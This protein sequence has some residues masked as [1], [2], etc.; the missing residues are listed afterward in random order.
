M[1]DTGHPE[2]P[3]T[4]WAAVS[5]SLAMTREGAR[6]GLELERGR[7]PTLTQ[8]RAAFGLDLDLV[9]AWDPLRSVRLPERTP[10]D[11]EII[12]VMDG[13]YR[14]LAS[15]R[16]VTVTA[17]ASGLVIDG[18]IEPIPVREG[19]ELPLWVLFDNPSAEPAEAEVAYAGST[20]AIPVDAGRVASLLVPGSAAMQGQDRALLDV[21]L[22][23]R[24]SSFA[25]PIAVLPAW[26]LSVSLVDDATGEPVPARVYLADDAGPCAPNDA[27]LRRDEHGNAF[28]HAENAFT[29]AVAGTARITVHRGME[30][31]PFTAMVEPPSSAAASI[32]AR[33]KRWSDQ[34]ADGWHSGDVHVHLHYGGE[35]LLTPEHASLVQR[36]EDVRFMNMMVAN[37]GSGY[38]NDRAWFTGHDHE[39]STGS[40]ILRWGEEYRNNFYGHLCMYGLE[41]LVPPIYSG[42]R[43]SEHE[44]DLPANAH[45]AD[46]AHSVGGTLS[47]A[48][49]MFGS[50][51]LDRIFS[52][53][54]TVEAKELPVDVALGKVD[55]LDVMSYPGIDIEVSELWYRL[56]NCGFQLPATA[57]TDTFMNFG[58]TGIFSNPPAVNRVFVQLDGPFTTEA[59]CEGVR[60]GRTF[61]TNGPMLRLTVDGQPVGSR[62]EARPGQSFEVR[63]EVTSHFP[64]EKLQLILNRVVVAEVAPGGDGRTATLEQSLVA[65]GSCW[66]ALR[67]LGDAGA[68]GPA[69]DLVLGGPLFAHT[70]PV[71]ID[72][73]G[74]PLADPAAA[75]YFV[76]WIDRLITMCRTDGRY[77]DDASRDEVIALFASAREVY[78]TLTAAV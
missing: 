66:V 10:S 25:I 45:A 61:V 54:R 18:A 77:P 72:V 29:V 73:P 64:I 28:F 78:E 50:I 23:D 20:S 9:P 44:H 76:E 17:T 14:G 42:F 60:A 2:Y 53:V 6:R 24:R 68:D 15:T 32:D 5:N 8:L 22:G 57:G 37:S 11:A 40:H 31:E 34:A 33:L 59:W 46:L 21:E 27:I 39:L 1:S 69:H 19:D 30:Y 48:H 43:L 7:H 49:P 52:V 74:V 56:L 3:L 41:E 62:I 55:A 38:V 65:A 26:D 35:Y 75:A 13:M 12:E 67:V 16:K 47:Y 4:L 58:G 70:S 51:D 71:Y 63:G 36:G